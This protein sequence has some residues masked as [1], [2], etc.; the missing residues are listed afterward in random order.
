M[1]E[2]EDLILVKILETELVSHQMRQI[3]SGSD[4]VKGIWGSAWK[5]LFRLPQA[6]PLHASVSKSKQGRLCRPTR[7]WKGKP[8]TNTCD[9]GYCFLLFLFNRKGLS[10]FSLVLYPV[11]G[12]PMSKNPMEKVGRRSWKTYPSGVPPHSTERSSAIG[13]PK[14][15]WV[16]ERSQGNS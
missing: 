3:K 6:Q 7:R 2:R 1:K 13:S 12:R 4:T 16:I 8:G 10:H 5:C 15:T 14:A 9:L 11:L